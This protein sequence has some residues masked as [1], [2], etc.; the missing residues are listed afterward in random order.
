MEFH[1]SELQEVVGMM[2]VNV[3]LASQASTEFALKDSRLP[4]CM[5]P[6]NDEEWA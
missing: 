4:D 3:S 1:P 5:L 6:G 2:F